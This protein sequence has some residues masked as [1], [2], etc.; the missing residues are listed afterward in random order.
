MRKGMDAHEPTASAVLLRP[1]PFFVLRTPHL[2]KDELSRW[3][4]G[5][6]CSTAEPLPDA[7]ETLASRLAGDRAL[8]RARLREL[9]ARPSVG[10]AI[11]VASRSLSERLPKWLEHPESKDGEK[12]EQVLVRYVARMAG[13]ATPFGL[14][15][16][17]SV[18][19][20]GPAETT[21]LEVLPAASAKRH[22]RLDMGYLVG[23]LE[24]LERDPDVRR[25]LTYR[26]NNALYE[27]A[28]RISYP[29]LITAGER[30]H[31]ELI[32]VT[33]SE[34]LRAA[35]A[36]AATGARR[37]D[38]AQVVL[39]PG[40]S[41]EDACAFV[42]ELIDARILESSLAP[43]LTGTDPLAA[44]AVAL[45]HVPAIAATLAAVRARLAVVNDA[46]IGAPVSLY[47][48]TAKLLEPLPA[49]V[50]TAHVFQVDMSRPARAT[51]GSRELDALA[52]GVR[53]LHALMPDVD[54]LGPFVRAF[55]A[56]YGEREVPLPEALDEEVGVGASLPGAIA[57]EPTPLLT[58]LGFRGPRGASGPKWSRREQ[59]L[60][61]KLEEAWSTRS[62]AIVLTDADLAPL[63]KSKREAMPVSLAAMATLLGDPADPARPRRILF[64]GWIG[65]SAARL[66]GRFSAWSLELAD[67]LRAH[68]REEESFAKDAIFAEVA[69]MPDAPRV[70]NIL[71]RPLLRDYEIAYC[72]RSGADPVHTISLSELTLSV[73][74]RR[75]RL[76]SPTLGR[77]IV[78]R[79][80]T[81][82]NTGTRQLAAYRF[83]AALPGHGVTSAASF[84]W[85]AL[86]GARRLPRVE[87]GDLILAPRQWRVD[88]AEVASLAQGSAVARYRAAA[89]LR[90]RLGLPRHVGLQDGDNVLPI[91]LDNT[92][93]VDALVGA[94]KGET[95]ARLIELFHEPGD[96]ACVGPDGAYV[97]ELV[98]PF[99]HGRAPDPSQAPVAGA[100]R[101][102]EPASRR[103]FSP[104]SEWCMV[105]LYCPTSA[106]DALLRDCVA[107]RI[108]S[109]TGDGVADGWFFT[110]DADPDPHVRLCV[111]GE[112]RP[113]YA[114]V[115]PELEQALRP[116]VDAGRVRRF[117]VAPYERALLRD[118]GDE[119]VPLVERMA[120]ADSDAALAILALLEDVAEGKE[121]WGLALLGMHRA[122]DDLG[123]VLDARRR[124][125]DASLRRWK[126]ELAMTLEQE[127]AIAD[128]YRRERPS[129][130]GMLEGRDVPE[131]ASAAFASRGAALRPLWR[132]LA[133]IKARGRLTCTLD[134]LVASLQDGWLRRTMRARPREH[135]V[136]LYAFLSK[137]YESVAAR[138][139]KA[140]PKA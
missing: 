4:D 71:L 120:G 88:E 137:H 97:N 35:L 28:G 130:A 50:D 30:R 39:E 84:G 104:G 69:H 117:V 77:E 139:K 26:P 53:A 93:S 128:R 113:L 17:F 11:Y 90:A 127:R 68:L 112:A 22:V 105:K 119:A 129:F 78:P 41:A 102:I 108:A 40:M 57:V 85:G 82:H 101:N 133:A 138:S 55:T 63:S 1:A 118:G 94:L 44:A 24:A 83:L 114:R 86:G 89:A 37:A 125:V 19:A 51:L 111:H 23:L 91:D 3:S 6:S 34:P 70:A 110:R 7:D 16:A 140:A 59:M 72:G 58:G 96:R 132:E 131:A 126:S 109:W 32:A 8:L 66:L 107:P 81:A 67:A 15:A 52:L 12:A 31:Y 38:I 80:S 10:E 62:G 73:R 122:F 136:V 115:L 74:R 46:P 25:G 116:L 18:G 21:H 103:S 36:V 2:S 106:V 13:R 124:V 48:D 43:S 95:R 76:F 98:L 79:L 92:L 29:E 64:N 99:V 56:R 49:R 121:R 33:P 42:D 27:V 123:Y 135:A 75:V 47:E 5:I 9:I 100:S 65:A 20:A 61:G 60:L 54:A 87:Y 134:S 14:F 45:D